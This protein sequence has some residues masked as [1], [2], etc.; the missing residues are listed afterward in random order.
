MRTPDPNELVDGNK[1]IV[2]GNLQWRFT[3]S[4]RFAVTQ[5]VY[6]LKAELRQ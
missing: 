2:I 6:A 5:Q 4:P 3:P 1:P